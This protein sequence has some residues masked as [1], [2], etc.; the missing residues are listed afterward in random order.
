VN[1]GGIS[2]TI[3]D[4][5]GV[6]MTDKKNH[7]DWEPNTL[8][9]H[10][11]IEELEAWAGEIWRSERNYYLRTGKYPAP[12]MRKIGALLTAKMFIETRRQGE[13]E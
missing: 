11:S 13:T 4:H 1:A 9:E 8:A 5:K 2:N 12:A 3:T 10:Y 7:F 6:F